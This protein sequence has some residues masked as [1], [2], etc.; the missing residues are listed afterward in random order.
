VRERITIRPLRIEDAEAVQGY[1]SDELVSRTTNIP[2]PYPQDGGKSFVKNAMK[3]W[4]KKEQ[5]TFSI[6]SANKMIGNVSLN[7]PDF[8]K[9]TVQCDYAIS[10]SCW[11]RGIAS[12]AIRLAVSYA[13][14]NLNMQIVTSVCL[15]RNPASA[16]VLE[17]NGFV[18]TGRFVYNS[19]KFQEELTHR[20]ELTKDV[21]TKMNSGDEQIKINKQHADG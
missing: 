13:F 4:K 21:W 9:H 17:K 7:N 3:S 19:E 20:F 12:E 6:L 8:N 14:Q 5:F 16:R 1:A 18:E 10:S 11:G 15:E 2:H